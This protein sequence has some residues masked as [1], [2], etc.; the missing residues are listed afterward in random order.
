[1]PERTVYFWAGTG[2]LVPDHA[3]D[4]PKAWSYRDLVFLRL[5]AFLRQHRV[6]LQDA[7]A[8]VTRY[9]TEFAAGENIDT[10]LSA[11][12]GGYAYGDTMPIDELTGQQA[13][14]TMADVCGHFDLLAPLDN[15]GVVAHLKGPNLVRPSRSTSISP[16]V[17]SGEPVVVNSRITTAT[18]FA[19]HERRGLAPRD[20][21][22]LYPTLSE[23]EVNDAIEMER[24]LRPAA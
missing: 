17:M 21:V 7:A 23:S 5:I 2:T 10:S 20:I 18:L 24:E 19:L 4:R 13:F 1:V 3:D 8:V 9:R 14:D 15:R 12:Q 11:A 22:G 6:D 16:W